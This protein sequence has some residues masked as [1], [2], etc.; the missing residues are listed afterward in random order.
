MKKNT[1][2]TGL[3]LIECIVAISI[4]TLAVAG[5]LTLAAH[6]LKASRDS[7]AEFIATHLAEEALEAVHN[8]RANNSA[9]DNT[10]NRSQWM[11]GIMSRCDT[12]CVLDVSEHGPGVWGQNALIACPS[13]NCA[14]LA[15]VYFN[16]Q[17]GLYRQSAASLPDPWRAS[18]FARTVTVEGI[19]NAANPMRQVRVTATVNYQGYAGLRFVKIT[20]DLYNWFPTLN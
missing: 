12:G 2:Q 10:P 18:E 1:H 16:S 3:T 6:S 17:T 20:E 11:Q 7:R 5:P 14:T 13:G 8:I 9:D 19:D 4:L 15:M